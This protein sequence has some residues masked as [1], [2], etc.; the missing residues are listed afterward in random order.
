MKLSAV[1]FMLNNHTVSAPPS[2]PCLKIPGKSHPWIPFGITSGS[3]CVLGAGGASGKWEFW[4]FGVGILQFGRCWDL[5]MLRI[6]EGL[7]LSMKS[8]LIPGNSWKIPSLGAAWDSGRLGF[9]DLTHPNFPFPERALF[10]PGNQQPIQPD[11]HEVSDHVLHGPGTAPH[12]GFRY[13]SWEF[14]Q[15]SGMWELDSGS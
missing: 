11:G 6:P 5:M 2:L 1:Q 3:L 12:G 14:R 13:F 10:L 15:N 8:K 9:Q 7:L 4:G